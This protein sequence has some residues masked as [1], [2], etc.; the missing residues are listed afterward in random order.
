MRHDTDPPDLSPPA[1]TSS[2]RTAAVRAGAEHTRVASEGLR[3]AAVRA[4]ADSLKATLEHMVLVEQ[5][6]RSVPGLL[7]V[8]P[9]D[10]N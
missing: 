3:A 8:K 2:L 9:L 10:T 1:D 4:T 6:R 7:D 5:L